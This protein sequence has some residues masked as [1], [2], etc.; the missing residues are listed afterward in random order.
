MSFFDEAN[1]DSQRGL[2]EEGSDG[3]RLGFQDGFQAA[4]DATRKAHSVL[5]VEQGLRDV[6][7]QQIKKIREAGLRPPDS[8]ND[9]ESSPF[10]AQFYQG[11]YQAAA[12]SIQDGGGWYTD[13]MVAARDAQIKRLQTERPDLGL[14]TY[15]DMFKQVQDTAQAAEKRA[16]SSTTPMGT[17][18]SF[19]GGMAGALDPV[20]NP[21]N[22][23][24]LGIGGGEGVVGRAAVQ[25][26]GQGA[27]ETLNL[28]MSDTE[29]LLLN[30]P[31]TPGED[32]K[33]IGMAVAGGVGADLLLQGAG[34]ALRRYR[35]GKWFA[36]Q[37]I[38]PELAKPSTAEPPAPTTFD[39]EVPPPLKP[40]LPLHEYPDWRS[41]AQAH[42]EE[43]AP[44][45]ASREAQPRTA[46]DLDHVTAELNRWDGPAPW[47]VKPPTTDTAI[48]TDIGEIKPQIGTR[49][50]LQNYMD[51]LETVDDVARRIDPTL[52]ER[53][54]KL[55][56][57]MAD[58]R[59][60]IDRN[61]P[62]VGPEFVAGQANI[63]LRRT[64]QNLDYQMRDMAPLVTR[65][66]KAAEKEW[67]SLPVDHNTIEYLKRVEQQ[68]GFRFRGEG[69]PS[70][71][72]QPLRVRDDRPPAP[73]PV[74]T[75]DAVPMASIEPNIDK[76]LHTDTDTAPT[77]VRQNV[78]HM[79]E[80]LDE[81]VDSFVTSAQKMAKTETEDIAQKTT[82][83]EEK[84]ASWRAIKTRE[85][86]P[87]SLR[88][89]DEAIAKVEK[90]LDELQNVTFPDGRK[91]SL[92]KDFAPF[93][94]PDGRV[95]NL[96]VRDYLRE[97]A[98]D[99]EALKA[100]STCSVPS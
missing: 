21:V 37:P 4:L 48:P 49:D 53:Y 20:S 39:G 30:R 26:L 83:L 32:I 60:T 31:R 8:L 3:P 89:F 85:R 58:I 66:Y 76:R 55:A 79:R 65:A 43:P 90:E 28:G 46:L 57:Q 61:G 38:P 10:L 59:K 24:T 29:N 25:G 14:M 15:A 42:G 6:E 62:T 70:L 17:V 80:K 84:L 16:Q 96:S 68:S 45:G 41:F 99:Q 93:V 88:E 92:D 73:Q 77:R 51:N 36:D 82:A 71:T 64:M 34:A 13:E 1:A 74:T 11:R 33:Q 100:V 81:K 18:G 50:A 95:E 44:Y 67:R 87:I 9:S 54:D 19:L 69:E 86:D 91:L 5:G 2:I 63:I 23:A 22:F 75:D 56:Q 98:K 27:A 97:M 12:H 40:G 7:Q 52:F 94:H 78:E 35:T 72:E 47:E